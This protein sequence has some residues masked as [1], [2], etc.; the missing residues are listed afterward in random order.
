M[1][2]SESQF[3]NWYQKTHPKGF[4]IKWPDYKMTGQAHSAGIPDYLTIDSGQ[5]VWYEVKTHKSR[6]FTPAQKAIFPV[7][8]SVGANIMVWEK[9]KRGHTLRKYT[10]LYTNIH[11]E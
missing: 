2:N 3:R 7:M 5:T 9:Q 6:T 1:T 4:I 10:N 11:S 8:Q